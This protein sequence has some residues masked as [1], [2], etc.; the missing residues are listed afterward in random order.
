MKRKGRQMHLVIVIHRDPHARYF[1]AQST[2]K[3]NIE[4][5]GKFSPLASIHNVWSQRVSCSYTFVCSSNNLKR[6]DL[7]QR[8]VR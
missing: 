1:K 2:M 3:I 8:P 5:S 4:R 6:H 7:C